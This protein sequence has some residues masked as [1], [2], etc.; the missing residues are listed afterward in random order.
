MK[1][2]TTNRKVK[3]PT[4]LTLFT[5]AFCSA[6]S[7]QNVV[8]VNPDKTVSING[9]KVFPISVYIQSD[10]QGVKDLGVNTASRPFCINANAV[11]QSESKGLYLHYT[12]G[13]GCDYEN[14]DAIRNRNAGAFQQSVNRV[15]NS[16]WIFGYGLPDEPKSATGLSGADTKW[17]YDVIKATDPNHPVFL[18][19]YANDISAYKNSAD[20]FLNDQY[21]FNNNLNPLYD[22]KVKL[23]NMQNQVA[24]KPVWLIIQT[25]S[26]FGMPTNEQI[27]AETYLSIALGSTGLIFYSYDVEDAGGVNHIK[28][29]G[30]IAFMKG[31]ISELKQFSPIFLG[32][33]NTNLA[34][35]SNDIDAILKTHNGKSYLIAV[36]KSNSAKSITFTLGG[37]GNQ[38]ANIVGLTSA[39]SSRV[40]QTKSISADGK[41]SDVLQGLEAV[42]YEIENAVPTTGVSVFQHC[43]FDGYSVML[44]PGDYTTQALAALGVRDNDV[45][46]IRVPVGYKATLFDGDNFVGNSVVRTEEDNCLVDEQ[47]NDKLSSLR[48]EKSLSENALVSPVQNGSYSASTGIPVRFELNADVAH[49]LLYSSDAWTNFA[50]LTPPYNYTWFPHQAGDHVL[51]HELYDANWNYIE[52]SSGSTNVRLNSSIDTYFISPVTNN[53]EITGEVHFEIFASDPNVGSSNGDGIQ[54]VLFELYKGTNAVASRVENLAGYDWYFDTS[55]LDDGLYTLKASIQSTQAAGGELNIISTPVTIRNNAE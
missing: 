21:P 30:D 41:L 29:D 24:P 5:L 12:A 22:I 36:N 9:T 34:Y 7:A 6:V 48:I 51:K 53:P 14:A 18:T 47:F 46:S 16:N 20:I 15:K 43:N 33:T 35:N 27:R 11:N 1:R 55:V 44:T 26:Q 13:P 45:S 52:G 49:V 2:R 19:D 32:S 28:K 37:L 4:L 10:W 42:V 39:G 38:Q 40:G 17:A 25:G 31:L 3:F 54:N 8:K 23:K 50:S